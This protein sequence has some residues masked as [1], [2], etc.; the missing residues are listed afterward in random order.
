MLRDQNSTAEVTR[1]SYREVN[2]AA[3]SIAILLSRSC[4]I[5][6]RVLLLH[7]PGPEFLVSLAACWYAGLVPVPAPLPSGGKN[8]LMPATGIALD[9]DVSVVLTD[10]QH[11]GVV[12][13]WIGQD[14]LH[15]VRCVSTAAAARLPPQ[16]L[17]PVP[18]NGTAPAYLHY[19][20]D[21]AGDPKGV[22]VSHAELRHRLAAVAR[23]FRLTERS[24]FAGVLPA[25]GGL[26]H[27]TMQLTPLFLGSTSYLL[28]ATPVH[29]RPRLWLESL[30][31]YDA[32]VCW[33]DPEVYHLCAWRMPEAD[34][35][36]LDLSR[37]RHAFT[38]VEERHREAFHWFTTRFAE[39]GF[40][41]ETVVPHLG[42][43]EA[44]LLAVGAV[45]TTADELD[46]RVVDP[47]T[48][49]EVPEDAVGEIW[50]RG[51]TVST[52]YWRRD[53]ES[54]GRFGGR[55]ADGERGFF[56]TGQMGVLKSGWL[57]VIGPTDEMITVHGNHFSPQ[58]IELLVGR[59][60]ESF[61]GLS[62]SVFSIPAPQDQL[63]VLQEVP[64]EKSDVELAMLADSVK[65]VVGRRLGV[66]IANV[67]L[68]PPDTVRRTPAGAVRRTLMR[69]L[70]LADALYACYEELDA[71]VHRNYRRAT[72][73]RSCA[74]AE[75]ARQQH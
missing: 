11:F 9:A 22:V 3:R 26:H 21:P 24:D 10:S 56:R 60:D 25:H 61:G 38:T 13:D 55:T 27:L 14:G 23:G 29:R 53:E 44:P 35:S 28:P 2:D 69:E 49:V 68:V 57:D 46:V 39:S 74:P 41:P 15:R 48:S 20:D 18:I 33:A 19:A 63:V 16:E 72:T 67:V 47:V 58:E 31:R 36:S 45:T 50:L 17:A 43:P 32:E 64:P 75:T 5:G 30:D 12:S 4:D 7:P 71:E 59:L 8:H 73:D 51:N 6:D 34:T 70:F 37:L 1:L 52:R 62:G 66:R 42:V 54:A 65:S 40:G